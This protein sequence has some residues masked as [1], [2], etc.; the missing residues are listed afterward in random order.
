MTVRASPEA[1]LFVEPAWD[2]LIRILAPTLLAAA[3]L[4]MGVVFLGVALLARSL[5]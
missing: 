5:G 1:S 3:I 2:V 4:L